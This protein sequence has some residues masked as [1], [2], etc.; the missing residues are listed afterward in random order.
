MTTE[1]G[2]LDI[3]SK[4]PP[5]AGT[6]SNFHPHRFVLDGVAC[7]SLEGFLQGL[8]VADPE[9]QAELCAM[10]GPKANSLGQK[11]D[12]KT[13]QLLYWRGLAIPRESAEYQALL[14]RAYAAVAAQAPKFCAALLATGDR[15]LTHRMG[16]SDPRATVLTEAE[17]CERLMRLRAT[18]RQASPD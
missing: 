8:K 7:G 18:L 5:P 15:P 6:L 17:M 13:D 14:D 2:P 10:A 12:W 3:R 4:A 9:A 16:K 1:D 11:Y